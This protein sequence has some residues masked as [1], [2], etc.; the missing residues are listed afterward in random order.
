MTRPIR[1]IVHNRFQDVPASYNCALG[2]KKAFEWA[3]QNARW[4]AGEVICEFSDGVVEKVWPASE[5][6]SK[7][8]NLLCESG[9]NSGHQYPQILGE[10]TENQSVPTQAIPT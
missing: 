1:Y 9:S 10:A 3:V 5:T 4:H 7:R 8:C 2:A 6:P